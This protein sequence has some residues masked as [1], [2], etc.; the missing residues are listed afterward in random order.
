[1]PTQIPPWLNFDPM[2]AVR[3]KVAAN[4]QR[5]NMEA[6]QLQ[7][8]VARERM[9]QDAQ[10]QQDALALKYQEAADQAAY[11]KEESE[12]R[13]SEGAALERL[14]Q[15]KYEQD[16]LEASIRMEGMRD[17]QTGVSSGESPAVAFSRNAHKLL[18]K[19]PAAMEKFVENLGE[20]GELTEQTTSGG[21]SFLS[22]PGGRPYFTPRSALP[23]AGLDWSE[24]QIAPGLRGVQTGPQ[25]MQ[26]TSR[27]GQLSD[28]EKA[29]LFDMRRQEA[30]LQQSLK[31]KNDEDIAE[32]PQLQQFQN[33]LQ[34]LRQD[35][36]QIY[37]KAGQADMPLITTKEDRDKLPAGTYYRDKDG[38]IAFKQ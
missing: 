19:N 14:R 2:E 13:R 21:A 28:L 6:A 9:M 30:F 4:Q 1:M 27:R 29:K 24:H 36:Q 34:E 18:Y 37:D 38:N 20:Q 8:Q 11:R 33:L 7:A 15:Q 25:S 35:R 16:A 12:R 5:N 31:G 17:Y 22:R 23:Q 26:I 10:Q 3:I 32:E